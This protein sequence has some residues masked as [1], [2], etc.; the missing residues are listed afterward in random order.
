MAEFVPLSVC[1]QHSTT[2]RK[3]EGCPACNA[4][5]KVA[6]LKEE[7]QKTIKTL[8]SSKRKLRIAEEIR[9]QLEDRVSEVERKTAEVVPQILELVASLGESPESM[10]GEFTKITAEI[11]GLAIQLAVL[12][13]D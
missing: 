2:Y 11:F 9:I 7:L 6:Q 10:N 8:N 13:E 4:G 12:P 5:V 1:R 3:N